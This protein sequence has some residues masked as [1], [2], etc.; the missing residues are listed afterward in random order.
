MTTKGHTQ[1][2]S[3]ARPQGA[4]LARGTTHSPT[5]LKQV[6][7]SS[8]PTAPLLYQ[9]LHA[10][11]AAAAPVAS[12]AGVASPSGAKRSTRQ[13]VKRRY[14]RPH[15][16][17]TTKRHTQHLQGAATARLQAPNPHIPGPGAQSPYS[18]AHQPGQVRCGAMHAL[19]AEAPA[20]APAAAAPAAAG[21]AAPLAA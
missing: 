19:T 8:S 10:H 6:C 7:R 20:A 3:A 9:S 14:P 12:A 18:C 13:H 2:P 17:L 5:I 4:A 16:H 11:T 21:V 1:T 15:A